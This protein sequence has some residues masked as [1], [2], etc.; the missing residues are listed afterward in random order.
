MNTLAK[1]RGALPPVR[2]MKR[3]VGSMDLMAWSAGCEA[4][5]VTQDVLCPLGNRVH[6][7]L[8]MQSNWLKLLKDWKGF[9][10]YSHGSIERAFCGVAGE[11]FL[12]QVRCSGVPACGV[13]RYNLLL[14]SLHC[15][16]S[17]SQSNSKERKCP[18]LK[19]ICFHS[20]CNK[21]SF[22]F[23]PFQKPIPKMH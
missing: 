12:P 23:F 11:C 5:T 13:L 16:F 8:S 19:M 2:W 3:Q 4:P 7:W 10:F 14:K 20:L 22:F 15:C 1:T 21:F 18:I 17:V 6:T 9:F